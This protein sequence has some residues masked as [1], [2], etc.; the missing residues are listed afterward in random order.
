MPTAFVLMNTETESE[1][2]ILRSLR[3]TCM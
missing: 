3:S 1:A 2:D